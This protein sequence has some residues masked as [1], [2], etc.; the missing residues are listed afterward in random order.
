MIQ[1]LAAVT[2]GTATGT[3]VHGYA[4]ERHALGLTRTTLPMR[5]L[6][7]GLD[8]LRIGFITDLHHS[9]FTG[10]DDIARAVKLVRAETPD[11][12]LLGGDYI[13]Y[14][15]LRY[16]APCAEALA[17]LDAPLGVFAILGN[18]DDDRVVPEVLGR[19]GMRVLRDES[20]TV[21]RGGDVLTLTGIRFWTRRREDIARA[22]ARRAG[23][24]LLAAHDPRRIYEADDLGV[25]GVL[26]GHTHGGQIVLPGLG[27]IAA[28]KFP[29]A[30]GHLA[31]GSTEMFVSRGVGTVVVPLR[32][33]CP[34]EVVIVTLRPAASGAQA[35]SIGQGT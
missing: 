34:P 7:P 35:S 4:Y 32:I 18:H 31:R 25:P 9:E 22:M 13:S 26:A 17:P 28:S 24:V 15:D 16:A 27:A 11:L 21:T 8:G 5:G 29:V 2:A 12:V 1:A 20:T 19:R 10:L 23:P 33:N 14:G 3:A 30:E 6:P